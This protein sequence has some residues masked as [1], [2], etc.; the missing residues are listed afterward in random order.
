MDLILNFQVF[1]SLL[2]ALVTSFVNFELFRQATMG[3]VII[4]LK[5]LYEM[6]GIVPGTQ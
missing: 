1:K 2:R 6:L 4:R 3:I 5:N